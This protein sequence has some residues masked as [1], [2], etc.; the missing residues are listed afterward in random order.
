[1]GKKVEFKFVLVNISGE[2][3]W[4][5]GP[6]R[7]LSL[8]QATTSINSQETTVTV[9]EEWDSTGNQTISLEEEVAEPA[10]ARVMQNEIQVPGSECNYG[11]SDKLYKTG[12]NPE[13]IQQ[14]V[15]SEYIS[16]GLED[17]ESDSKSNLGGAI[18]VPGLN[19]ERTVTQGND[20]VEPIET[21]DGNHSSIKEVLY[22]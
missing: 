7:V 13:T 22:C 19:P 9:W 15:D 18:L 10:E 8:D 6:N 12:E 21:G 5:P 20:G 16:N 2:V 4:Q 14:D 1:M 11:T 17:S 3:H